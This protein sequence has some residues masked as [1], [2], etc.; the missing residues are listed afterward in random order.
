MATDNSGNVI[1]Q[2]VTPQDG[3]DDVLT[4]LPM[5]E[6]E[7]EDLLYGESMPVEERLQR[8]RDL[9]AQ[10][11]DQTPADTGPNDPGSLLQEVER[12][13]GS[14]STDLARDPDLAYDE[15]TVDEDPLAH[16]ET[17][18]PDSDELEEIEE[19]DE[20]SLKGKEDSESRR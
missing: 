3:W 6:T 17:L 14:L 1:P 16:R 11:R 10:L 13:I 9:A 4:A 7:V 15:V 20:A 2:D 8:L 18:S 12:A 19:R 5:S